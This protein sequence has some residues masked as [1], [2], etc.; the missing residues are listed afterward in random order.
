MTDSTVMTP[1][2]EQKLADETAVE[3]G[4]LIQEEV[5]TFSSLL[6]EDVKIVT[7][8]NAVSIKRKN[9]NFVYMTH[10][11]RIPLTISVKENK[12]WKKLELKADN[13]F[14]N[15]KSAIANSYTEVAPVEK[16]K[17]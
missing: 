14:E 5:T 13:G 7:R 17:S 15:V 3:L 9:K 16:P 10:G 2:E 12:A 8:G 11:K 1:E 6:G 4:R